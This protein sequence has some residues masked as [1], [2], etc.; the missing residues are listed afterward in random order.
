MHR[1]QQRRHT[2]AQRTAPLPRVQHLELPVRRNHQQP[3]CTVTGEVRC[4]G[5]QAKQG[6]QPPPSRAVD[7]CRG[8]RVWRCVQSASSAPWWLAGDG[9][10]STMG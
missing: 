5:C 10:A 2:G 3:P 4:W 7:L 6:Q 8:R 1:R 9:R